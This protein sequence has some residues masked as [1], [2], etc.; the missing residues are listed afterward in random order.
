MAK[1]FLQEPKRAKQVVFD[2]DGNPVNFNFDVKVSEKALR[3]H[4]SNKNLLMGVKLKDPELMFG[5][6]VEADP[7]TAMKIQNEEW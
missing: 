7:S 5:W 3:I 2:G 1:G 4:G 6:I